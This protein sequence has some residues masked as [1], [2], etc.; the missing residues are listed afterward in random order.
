M[1]KH[2]FFWLFV[3]I[4]NVTDDT[5]VCISLIQSRLFQYTRI[6]YG[7]IVTRTVNELILRNTL[8]YLIPSL[9]KLIRF[10]FRVKFNQIILLICLSSSKILQIF[11]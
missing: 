9:F 6:R 11:Q 2:L 4:V 10:I 7:F 3:E 8:Q 1:W 5:R